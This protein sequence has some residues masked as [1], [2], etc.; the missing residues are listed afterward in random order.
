MEK[1]L[2]TASIDSHLIGFHTSYLKWFHEQGYEVHSASYGN[3][4]IPYVHIKHNLPFDRSPYR[5]ANITV[6]KQLKKLILEN[7]YKLIHCHT[8]VASILTRLAARKA[9]K[10]GTKVIYTAHGFHFFKGAPLVNW[11]FYY[12]IEWLVARWT[13]CI[14]T[15]NSEDYKIAIKK[16]PCKDIRFVNGVGIDL[17]D[18][19]APTAETKDAFREQYGYPK[20]AFILIYAGELSYRKHQDLLIAAI[21]DVKERIPNILLLL[22]GEGDL[23]EQYQNQISQLGI[24]NFVFLLGYRSDIK[25]LLKLSDIAVSA[26]RQEGLPVN[27]MEGMATGLPLIVTDCRGNRD[28]AIASE[29]GYVIGVDDIKGFSD[30]IFKLYESSEDRLLFSNRNKEIIQ[31]YSIENIVKEMALIYKAYL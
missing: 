28:L 17:S 23:R 11:L 21:H 20:D 13:D 15:M 26:S 1:V 27:V 22:A 18:F 2:F 24:E 3:S 9:R 25:D 6:Y 30:A 14:I 16:L 10:K 31:K 12:A 29:N 19:N 5:I 4:T 7:D 8:P